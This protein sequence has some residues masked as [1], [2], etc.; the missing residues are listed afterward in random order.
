MNALAQ[1]RA[2]TR[3]ATIGE[4]VSDA[5]RRLANSGIEKARLDARLLVG[6]VLGVG[7]EV[8][9]GYPER[10]M[11]SGVRGR[12]A[13]LLARRAGREPIARI[14]GRREFWSL[15]FRITA[16]T[17]DPRPDSETVVRS[18]LDALRASAA[19][20][21]RPPRI[22]DLGSGSG[23]LLLALLH[24][25]PEAS[26]VGVDR[27]EAAV[28][29]A[30]EN[31]ASLGLMDRAGFFV[32]DWGAGLDRDFDCIVANPPYIPD[33]EIAS[34]APEVAQF[35]PRL[36]LSGGG[37]GLGCYR[38]I[39]TQLPRLLAPLGAASVEIGAG[40]AAAVSRIFRRS[41]L[42]IAGIDRD[43]NGHERCLKATL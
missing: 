1:T 23:C 17:L 11:D 14:L 31:A 12:L 22:L 21:G 41:G 16:D 42:K 9:T 15:D 27:S 32:G 7:P 25:L 26:G 35:E 3:A 29:V 10:A 30:R 20:L 28:S 5:A 39:A 43:L 4:A 6:H 8:V 37:D 13:S 38:T 2:A 40:Q 34:L 18:A 24:E 33:S 19:A 36:A